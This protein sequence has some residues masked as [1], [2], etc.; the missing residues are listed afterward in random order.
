MCI[1]LNGGEL[2]PTTCDRVNCAIANYCSLCLSIHQIVL[3]QYMSY[4]LS[5]SDGN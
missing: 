5:W 4:M 2:F 1:S 3:Y